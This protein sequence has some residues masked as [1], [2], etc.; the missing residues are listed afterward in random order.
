MRW[1]TKQPEY[2][3]GDVRF[4]RKFLW[5]PMTIDGETR[6]LETACIKQQV[7][8]MDMCELHVGYRVPPPPRGIKVR[9]WRVVGWG[10]I[11]RGGEQHPKERPRDYVTPSKPWPRCAE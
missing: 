4:V 11:F 10:E 7:V 9:V 3:V 2:K 1:G 5:L 8:E 6:W